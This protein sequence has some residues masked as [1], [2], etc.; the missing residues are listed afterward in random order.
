MY[1]LCKPIKFPL[2]ILFLVWLTKAGVA[3]DVA[4]QGFPTC[5]S[6]VNPFLFLKKQ[7]KEEQQ[8]KTFWRNYYNSTLALLTD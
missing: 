7:V 6:N 4:W 1:S 3:K 5:F 2:L 8:Q